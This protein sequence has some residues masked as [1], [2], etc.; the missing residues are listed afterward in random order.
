MSL[1]AKIP[2]RTARLTLRFFQDDDLDALYAYH[3][4]PEVARYLYWEAKTLEETR[5]DLQKKLTRTTLEEDGDALALGAVLVDEDVLIGEVVLVLHSRGHKQGE[6]G[7]AFNPDYHGRGYATEA[8]AAMIDLGFS[9]YDF[10]RIIGRCDALNTGSYR[11][12]ERLGMRRE[13]HFVE[14]EIFKGDWGDEFV[15]AILKREWRDR[16]T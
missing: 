5:Q 4:R 2:I 12:M 10:H 13:A 8:V 6:V 16:S 11:L 3:S 1:S 15:Y 7:F 9:E 14:N